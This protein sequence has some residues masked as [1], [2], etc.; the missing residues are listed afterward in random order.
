VEIAEVF[1]GYL[2]CLQ[3]V[4]TTRATGPPGIVGK[5]TWANVG[6]R[7]HLR[8]RNPIDELLCGVRAAQ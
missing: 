2:W 8:V 5:L 1:V 4:I 6:V 3:A 7:L